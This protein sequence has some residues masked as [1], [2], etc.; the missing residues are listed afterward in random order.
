MVASLVRVHHTCNLLK[1]YFIIIIF[2]FSLR[3]V[4]FQFVSFGF[5]KHSSLKTTERKDSNLLEKKERNTQ[6]ACL[7]SCIL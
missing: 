7:S 5:F 4:D 1:I 3:L 2:F 6:G